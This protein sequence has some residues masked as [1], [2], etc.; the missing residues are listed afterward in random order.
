MA[1][2]K[3][4]ELEDTLRV[5][6]R[7]AAEEDS[8]ARRLRFERMATRISSRLV[9]PDDLD[10]AIAACLA[11]LGEVTF[12]G[13]AAVC[14]LVDDGS[15]L[16]IAYEWCVD[17]LGLQAPQLGDLLS[18]DYTW[19][20]D[21]LRAGEAIHI[22]DVTQLPPEAAA[23]AAAM[24]QVGVKSLLALPLLWQEGAGGFL[25]IADVNNTG[26][27][28]DEDLALLR[29]A[30]E[31]IG[32]AL[33]QACT[34][35]ELHTLDQ[36]YRALVE[37][38]PDAI[39]QTSLDLEI[40]WANDVAA[41]LLRYD[42]PDDLV[43]TSGLSPITPAERSTA[44][45]NAERARKEGGIAAQPY[46]AT[47]SDGSSLRVEVN[48]NLLLDEDGDPSG[49]IA[50]IR[51]ITE[52]EELHARLAQS[53]RMAS[54]GRLA[55]GVAH[56]INN[57]LT[58][59]LFNV[60][61]LA[62]DLPDIEAGIGQLRTW[63]ASHL[64]PD[65]ASRALAEMDR[66][67]DPTLFE[68]LAERASDAAIGA[69]RIRGIVRDLRTFSRVEDDRKVPVH[70]RSVIES[71]L[72]MAYNEIRYRARLVKEYDRIP[73]VL[74]TEGRLGQVFLNLVINAAQS[75][76]EGDADHNVIRVR[77]WQEADE[78]CASVEDTGC[79]IA[80]QDLG[81]VF[82][83]FYTTKPPGIGL[84]LG[85]PICQAI[86]DGAGGRID[87]ESQEGEGSRFVVRLP[88]P[89]AQDLD[90]RGHTPL[91]AGPPAQTRR[92][93][94]VVDDEESVGRMLRRALGRRF[95]VTVT[96]SGLEAKRIFAE[97][98]DYDVV[99]CDMLM[100]GMTGM[101]LHAYLCEEHPEL[102]ARMVFMTGGA[103]TPAAADFLARVDNP[104]LDKPFEL[105]EL[106]A[107]LETLTEGE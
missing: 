59:V 89:S 25:A 20:M 76:T 66:Q 19:W 34:H 97:S 98:T 100:P 57:P 50:V 69:E 103:F 2:T 8:L 61:G 105:A 46:T 15:P 14:L 32:A 93:A 65:L 62:S 33:G 63:L 11:D 80:P 78:I 13:R 17:D 95:D 41:K 6:R 72:R 4:G 5:R 54:V 70:L 56:E 3:N 39:V 84:G 106:Q 21:R 74:G 16:D 79:G 92:R 10:A 91:P 35:A 55:A 24:E 26:S 38:S 1:E 22:P 83:P 30:A 52:R 43:G 99:L 51:D 75:I 88:V 44:L 102:A 77:T 45:A 101:E 64:E 73:A 40:V 71:V 107:V 53:D 37:A 96:H 68:D 42:S 85:L 36:R 28:S 9:A 81:S 31:T 18:D 94:L 49:F 29:L 86:V 82:V 48:A 7:Q 104:R 23:E 58:Y 90:Q 87:V 12:A 47:R 27:W 60:Q 67:L